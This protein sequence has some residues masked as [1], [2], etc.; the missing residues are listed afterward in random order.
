[1]DF[2]EICHAEL[3]KLFFLEN[4]NFKISLETTSAQT[5]GPNIKYTEI[6]SEII[7][8][9]VTQ[10]LVGLILNIWAVPGVQQEI[11]LALPFN[12]FFAT[13]F[14]PVNEQLAFTPVD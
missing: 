4:V 7:Q 9:R 6:I 12:G 10:I 8:D 5:L 1:M 2:R 13:L 11:C 3:C 14:S